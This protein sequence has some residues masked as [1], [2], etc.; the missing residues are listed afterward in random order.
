MATFLAAAL[1][2]AAT[3]QQG[4]PEVVVAEPL[5]ETV[6][7]FDEYTGRFVAR[8]SVEIR[9]R[10]SVYL[11]EIHITEGQIVERG[12]LLYTID[13]RPFD[14]TERQARARLNAAVALRDL[15]EIEFGR[16][17][18][19]EARQVGS[20]RNVQQA[21]ASLQEALANV[22]LAEAELEQAQLD[23]EFIPASRRL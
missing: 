18:E 19:L 23:L 17:E 22:A 21:R 20:T 10:V 5:L 11:D 12:Q 9:A 2:T 16:A 7:D 4:P 6:I 1:T 13:T 14:L 15:A 8:Q 3:A